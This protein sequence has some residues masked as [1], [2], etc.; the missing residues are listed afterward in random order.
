MGSRT[1]FIGGVIAGTILVVIV[2]A[3]VLATLASTGRREDYEEKEKRY[4]CFIGYLYSP[5]WL[6]NWEDTKYRRFY[7]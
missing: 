2:V 1:W 5:V 3:I 4:V 7:L 6:L